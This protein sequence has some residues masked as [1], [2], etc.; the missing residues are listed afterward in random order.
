MLSPAG[1]KGLGMVLSIHREGAHETHPRNYLSEL[2]GGTATADQFSR[3]FLTGEETNGRPL[4]GVTFEPGKN[5]NKQKEEE[6]SCGV[7]EKLC[8]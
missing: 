8:L 7:D 3:F 1:G 5:G 2:F 4:K 6:L